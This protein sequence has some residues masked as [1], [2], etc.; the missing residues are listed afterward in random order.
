MLAMMKSDD[1]IILRTHLRRYMKR[2]GLSARYLSLQS[3]LSEAAAKQILAGLVGSPRHETIR[4]FANV[5]A[6][7]PEHLTGD[8]ELAGLPVTE[9]AAAEAEMRERYLK[10]ERLRA[11]AKQETDI[12]R[13][14]RL[15]EE[16]NRLDHIDDVDFGPT[17]PTNTIPGD[18]SMGRIADMPVGAKDLPIYASAQG[19]PEGITIS[20]DP[21]EY[22]KRPEPL[23]NV[24]G[25]FGMYMI[26]DSMFPKF[27]HADMILVHPTKPVRA[28]DYVLV[29]LISDDGEHAALVKQLVRRADDRLTLRQFNPDDEFEFETKRIHGVYLIV[30]SYEAR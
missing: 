14:Q 1:S 28:G 30:G 22:V 10:P 11:E 17:P 5:L 7:E 21:I 16:A 13:R 15:N 12:E 8:A 29:V 26:N 20:F 9:R 19:G 2:L 3:G 27:K 18:V 25:G 6:C 23:F 4:A 24:P